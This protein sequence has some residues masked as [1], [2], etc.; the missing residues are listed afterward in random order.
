MRLRASSSFSE[1]L[2]DENTLAGE[3]ALG[4]GLTLGSAFGR[5]ANCASRSPED[6]PL[7]L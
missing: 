3:G 5:V 6:E 4:R 7:E 1:A 2:V